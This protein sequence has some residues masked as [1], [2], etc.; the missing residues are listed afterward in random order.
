VTIPEVLDLA[1]TPVV[2]LDRPIDLAIRASSSNLFV[3]TKGGR[4]VEVAPDTGEVVNELVDI[5]DQITDGSE[6]GLLG[7][8]FSPDG[9]FLYL[10]YSDLNGN[11]NLVEMP[12]TYPTSPR[13]APC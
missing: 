7:I 10:S 4:V 9:A 5:G 1:L 13:L 2:E 8:D 3:A 11:N 12:V 6:T